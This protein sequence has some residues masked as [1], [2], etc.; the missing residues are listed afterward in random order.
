MLLSKQEQKEIIEEV[1][2]RADGI[3]YGANKD[4]EIDVWGLFDELKKISETVTDS[5]YTDLSRKYLQHIKRALKAVE[6]SNHVS[7]QKKLDAAY[8][9]YDSVKDKTDVKKITIEE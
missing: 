4:G 2:S 3:V 5:G 9:F 1:K 7:A 8:A 6:K